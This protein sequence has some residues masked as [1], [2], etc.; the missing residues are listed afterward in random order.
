MDGAPTEIN[1]VTLNCW[2]LKYLSK[3]RRER[4]S[5]VGRRLAT[6]DP[7]PH[8]V[9]LQE[10]WTQ[11]DYESI[12]RE[13]RFV[14]PYGKFYF[15]GVL[16]AGLAILSR[17]PIEESSMVAYPLNGKPTAFYRGDWFVGKGVACARIRYGP[18]PTDVVEVFNTHVSRRRGRGGFTARPTPPLAPRSPPLPAY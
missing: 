16:G 10:C 7:S 8:I 1:V 5:E 3:L 2:G 17:W 6:S 11:E 13:T 18:G 12:R 4:L 14:L 9:A 15:S